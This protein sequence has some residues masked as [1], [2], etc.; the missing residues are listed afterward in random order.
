MCDKDVFIFL[1]ECVVIVNW[2][3]VDL[4][5]FIYC[6][7]M[8]LGN[9]GILGMEIYVMGLYIVEYNF[10]VV[11]WENVVILLEDDYECNYDYDLNLLEGYILL[12][13]F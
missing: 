3:N 12:S 13:M 5:I 7:V 9:S 6:N 8:F 2:V 4:F 1:Y 11:K 10:D